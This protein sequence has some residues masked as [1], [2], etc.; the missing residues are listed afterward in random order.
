[1]PPPIS[2]AVE[3]AQAAARGRAR[4]RSEASPTLAD[5]LLA[6]TDDDE[7]KPAT[8]LAAAGVPVAEL[9]ERLER[10]GGPLAPADSALFAAGRE[11]AATLLGDATLTTD[12]LLLAVLAAGDLLA[13]WDR[14]AAEVEA[15]FA[16]PRDGSSQPHDPGPAL[17]I[18]DVDDRLAAARVLDASLNRARESLRVLDDYSRFVRQDRLLTEEVKTLRHRLAD[19]SEYLPARLLLIGRDTPGDVGTT[20][21]TPGESRR[22][23]AG[24]VAAVNLKRLQESL[25]SCEEFGKLFAPEFARQIESIRYASYTLE[26][27]FATTQTRHAKLAEARLYALLTGSQCVAAL[28]WTIAEAAAGGVQIVQLREKALSDRD[29]V[30][31]ARQV[32]RWTQQAGV[33]FVVNDR[34]D[35]ARLVDADGVHLGQDD[36]SVSDARRVVGP[37]AIVGVSTHDVEQVR[38][39]V[40]DG[41]DYL[42]VG[43][44]FPSR[45]KPF[46]RFPGLEFVRE[47][48]QLTRTPAFALGGIDA[49]TVHQAVEAGAARVAVGA[50]L[51]TAD[52]PAAVA[53]T[54]RY[55]L[56]ARGLGESGFSETGDA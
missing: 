17:V 32:R 28:D 48:S 9:R 34:P 7:G 1:M 39:A 56:A 8:T 50:A 27:A 29:L 20:L 37:D 45:T 10:D 19:A 41:A 53:R 54:L 16:T 4:S 12:M 30:A 43:P 49:A 46:D 38:R 26:R 55:A 36:L 3:R 35:I 13:P 31:R 47:V 11:K 18:D 24:H 33:L 25:R 2:P 6:L 22:R 5:W 14:T 44:T 51:A 21:N 40:L 23:T 52:E 42:G 15:R